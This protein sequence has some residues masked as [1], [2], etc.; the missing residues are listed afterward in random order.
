MNFNH[1]K[2]LV[3][4]KGIRLANSHDL[5]GLPN[6]LGLLDQVNM[7]NIRQG[8]F[9]PSTEEIP[10][11]KYTE[12]NID[13]SQLWLLFCSLS[14]NL[15]SI[16][17]KPMIGT[18]D[19]EDI[20]IG[21]YSNTV[22]TIDLLGEFEFHL[23]NDCHLQFGFRDESCAVLVTATKYLKVWT[24]KNDVLEDIMREYNLLP[25]DDLQFIDEFPRTTIS[26]E[27]NDDFY[28]Y[29]DLAKHL[30]AAFS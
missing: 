17:I 27:Y 24:D 2:M 16:N 8:Y 5:L 9:T 6:S 14:K 22:E 1:K 13:S 29:E 19:E 20:F 15:L 12:I 26:L 30:A 18:I 23:V 25:T 10:T 3:F 11:Q 28:S 4:P 21:K 7:A